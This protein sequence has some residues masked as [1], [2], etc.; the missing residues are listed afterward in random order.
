MNFEN[1]CPSD[2]ALVLKTKRI[3]QLQRFRSVL[4]NHDLAFYRK[5]D[6]RGDITVKDML[7]HHVTTEVGREV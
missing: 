3:L 4:V 2:E 6:D 1:G 7:T 5:L